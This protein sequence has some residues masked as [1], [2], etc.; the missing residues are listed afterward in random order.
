MRIMITAIV[1]ATMLTTTDTLHSTYQ[2]LLAGKIQPSPLMYPY[3][4]YKNTQNQYQ[5]NEQ[6]WDSYIKAQ[7]QS[8]RKRKPVVITLLVL[9]L[10]SIKR[11]GIHLPYHLCE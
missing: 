5:Q 4:T 10:M 11:Q 6:Q 7:H 3:S 8:C 1:T 2:A 9:T